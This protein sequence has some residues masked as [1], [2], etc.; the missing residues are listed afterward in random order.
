MIDGRIC[1]RCLLQESGRE[2]I[3]LDIEKHKAKI[4]E[5]ERTPLQEYKKRLGICGKCENLADG[6]CL[7]C[8]CY[9]EFRGAFRKQK[10]PANKWGSI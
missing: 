2:D 7:K 10:C 1:R 6:C 9:P 3:Y 5:E 8:G 4:P